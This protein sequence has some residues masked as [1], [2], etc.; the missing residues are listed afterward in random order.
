MQKPTKKLN[1]CGENLKSVL[2]GKN[3]TQQQIADILGTT[4][5]CISR[6]I[7]GNREPSLDDVILLCHFLDEDPNSLLGFY[8]IDH[9]ELDKHDNRL[10][11]D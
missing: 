5:E 1:K 6:W 2:I 7:N 4:Q 3:L 8:E 10:K 11:N 9:K